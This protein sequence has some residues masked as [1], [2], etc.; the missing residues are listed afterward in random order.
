MQAAAKS[1]RASITG[2]SAIGRRIGHQADQQ[3]QGGEGQQ[4]AG[5]ASADGQQ[6]TLRE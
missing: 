4:D 3:R 2:V 6:Q 1:T 5:D